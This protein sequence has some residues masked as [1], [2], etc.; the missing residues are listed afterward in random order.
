MV[1]LNNY[2]ACIYFVC[3]ISCVILHIFLIFK[4]PTPPL[5]FKKCVHKHKYGEL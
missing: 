4:I 3:T 5:Q 2:Q 1:H